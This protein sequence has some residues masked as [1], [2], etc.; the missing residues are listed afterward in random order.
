MNVEHKYGIDAKRSVFMS[1]ISS[2]DTDND[3][4]ASIET[5]GVVGRMVRVQSTDEQDG[6]TL[7]VELKSEATR[8]MHYTSDTQDQ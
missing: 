6:N 5:Y 4:I 2:T 7:I 8:A 3:I 1:G